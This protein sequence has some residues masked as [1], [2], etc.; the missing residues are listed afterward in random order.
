[1]KKVKFV[2]L[3][4]QKVAGTT[5]REDFFLKNF[6]SGYNFTGRHQSC[7]IEEA[8]LLGGHRQFNF[9]KNNNG[10]SEGTVFASV[11]REPVERVFSLFHF[12]DK[13]GQM[14]GTLGDNVL[15]NENFQNMI[16]NGQNRYLSGNNLFTKT[17]EH[18]GERNFL[19]GIQENLGDFRSVVT[20]NLGFKFNQDSRRNV[21]HQGY[22]ESL[23]IS[24]EAYVK[25]LELVS[26]DILLYDFVRN[27]HSGL[28]SNVE[29]HSW[30][31]LRES[32]RG[33]MV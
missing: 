33:Y 4:I 17:V 5:L 7:T 20:E 28:F 11:L 9:Y 14:E 16:R 25:L 19:V 22:K 24:E 31:D 13:K 6:D 26:Q 27:Y 32:V 29:E 8:V 2:F 30:V 10:D 12:H 21:G 3:H 1:M 23:E 15:Y 18:M